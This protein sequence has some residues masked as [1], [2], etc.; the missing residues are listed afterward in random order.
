MSRAK[1]SNEG[2]IYFR[3]ARNKWIAQYYDYDPVTLEPV[4]KTKSF[5]TPEKARRYLQTIMYQKENPVYIE[6]NGITLKDLMNTILQNKVDSNMISEAQQLRVEAIQKNIFKGELVNKKIEDITPDE[7]QRFLNTFSKYSESSLKK[8]IG[9][10]RQAFNYAFD[11]GYILR[12]PMAQVVRPKS[13]KENKVV[14]AMTLDEENKFVNY[15]QNKTL[16]ECPHKNEYLIQLFMGLRVGECLALN[17][18]DIDLMNR[19]IYV[20]K[21]L[22]N[23]GGETRMSDSPKTKAGKRYFFC[24]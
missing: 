20:H 16:K 6:K 12:N 3:K 21:T 4:K 14:R 5:D 22:T 2:S 9:Q 19:K 18:H 8:I 7:I 17:V 11:R 15:I 23:F 13:L 10:F 1:G 24:K